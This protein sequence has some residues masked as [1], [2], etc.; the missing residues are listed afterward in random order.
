VTDR[1]LTLEDIPAAPE[2]VNE[3]GLTKADLE[4]RRAGRPL[5]VPYNVMPY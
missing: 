5:P 2:P 1:Q 4:W 3:Q